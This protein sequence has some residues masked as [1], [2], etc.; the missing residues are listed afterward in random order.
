M[1][2][3]FNFYKAG[4]FLSETKQCPYNIQA[5]VGLLK[6][7]EI[8]VLD[9]IEHKRILNYYMIE[10]LYCLIMQEKDYIVPFTLDEL[11]ECIR[12]YPNRF[13]KGFNEDAYNYLTALHKRLS[14]LDRC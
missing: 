2:E 11:I 6:Y 13:C 4:K 9:I 1:Y 12:H 10:K 5:V 7:D 8:E 14:T 3:N